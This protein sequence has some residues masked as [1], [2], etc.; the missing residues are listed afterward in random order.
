MLKPFEKRVFLVADTETAGDFSAP[1]V[2]DFAYTITD[3]KSTLIKRTFLIDEIMTNP[4]LM[5][6]AFYHRKVYTDYLREL[7]EGN[8]R[9]H[10]WAD[11]LDTMRQDMIDYGVNCFCAY[12]LPFDK[13]AMTATHKRLGN[14]DKILPFAVDTLDLY[15]F[16]CQTALRSPIYHSLADKHGWRSDAGNVRT[17]AEHTFRFLSTDLNFVEKHTALADAE[18]E[19]IILRRLLDKKKTIPYNVFKSHPWRAA[20]TPLTATLC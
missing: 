6:V 16:A 4:D 9:L 12:N 20:Q 8:M 14:R 5:G 18:I 3:R 15:Y 1:M 11:A 7:S 19:T 17:T 10:S 13:G 2:Y